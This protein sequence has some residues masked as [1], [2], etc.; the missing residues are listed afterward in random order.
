MLER[1]RRKGPLGISPY[2]LVIPKAKEKVKKMLGRVS[3]QGRGVAEP[4]A[5]LARCSHGWTVN[6]C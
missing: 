2:A 3:R 4:Q 6:K 5:A 1:C